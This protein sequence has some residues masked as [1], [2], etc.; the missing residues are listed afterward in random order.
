MEVCADLILRR[1]LRGWIP[2]GFS[3]DMVSWPG[4]KAIH[5]TSVILEA[6]IRVQCSPWS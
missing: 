2:H 4:P 3:N 1:V 6:R 5:M